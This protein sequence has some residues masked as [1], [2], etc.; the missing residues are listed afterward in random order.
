MLEYLKKEWRPTSSCGLDAISI[1]IAVYA[2]GEGLAIV[3][4]ALT[5]H[6]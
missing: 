6:R 3:Y 1:F 4:T 2:M 5:Y